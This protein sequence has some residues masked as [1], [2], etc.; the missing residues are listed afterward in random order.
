MNPAVQRRAV[1]PQGQPG[2]APRTANAAVA[3]FVPD[4][5]SL[6]PRDF[7]RLAEFI[8]ETAGIKLPESKISMLE[9]RLRRRVRATGHSTIADYCDWLFA[10]NLD[11]EE[12]VHLINAVTTNK[13]DFF[14]EPRHFDYLQSDILP[15]MKHA[16]KRTIRAWSAA[17]STGAEPYTLAMVLDAFATDHGGP[18]YGILATD[19]DTEVLEVARRGIYPLDMVDPVPP[20]LRNRYVMRAV[21]SG[22]RD[23]RIA[24]HLRAAIGFGRLNLMDSRYPVGEPMDIIFCRNVLIYF[25]KETQAQVIRR[26]VDCLKPGGHLFLGHSES[27]SETDLP[28]TQVANTTFRRT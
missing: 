18:D 8:G 15:A 22:R 12:S 6:H 19:L 10:G 1:A 16:G 2:T 28:I 14:R 17:C 20:T 25:D 9:G 27:M 11:E 26:L 5:D 3:R 7:A 13:T 24:P 21:S 4:Q 23:V